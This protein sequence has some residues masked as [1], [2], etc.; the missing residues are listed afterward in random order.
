MRRFTV[1]LVATRRIRLTASS[2]EAAEAVALTEAAERWP[3]CGWLVADT[4]E[5]EL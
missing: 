2:V 4:E 3:D 1:Y 5:E